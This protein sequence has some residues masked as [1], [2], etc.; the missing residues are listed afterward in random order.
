MDITL[1]RAS[2]SDQVTLNNLLHLYVHDFSE[3]VGVVPTEQGWFS[4]PH[5]P[6]YWQN[7][8]R[9]PFLIRAGG[10]LAGF[11]LT[12]RGSLISGDREVFDLAEFFV[13]RGLRRR[14]VGKAAASAIF[15]ELPGPWEVR[16]IGSNRPAQGFWQSAIGQYTSGLFTIDPWVSERGADGHVFRFTSRGPQDGSDAA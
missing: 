1:I 10:D 12:S 7:P 9:T 5:L 2:E 16:V 4:Y 3:F 15:S 8:D 14:G 13:V 11:A 6:L